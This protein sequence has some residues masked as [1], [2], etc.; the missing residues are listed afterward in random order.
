MASHGLAIFALEERE[1]YQMR[2]IK[3]LKAEEKAVCEAGE[4]ENTLANS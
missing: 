1:K 2:K 3:Q 4:I